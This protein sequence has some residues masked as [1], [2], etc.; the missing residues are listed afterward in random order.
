MNRS[1]IISKWY[2]KLK[3]SSCY[4]EEFYL[5]LNKIDLQ[6]LSTFKSYDYKNNTPQ[7]NLLACL[8]FCEELEKEYQKAG[9]LES[10]L[11]DSLQDLVLW[12]E[13]YYELNNEIGLTEL[14]WISR[15][16]LMQIFRLGRLQFS[17]FPSEFD[18]AELGIKVNDPVLEV[19]IP[20]G[21]PLLYDEC[22]KSFE[23]AKSFFKK[24]YPKY[25]TE[26]CLCHSWLLDETLLQIIG[27]NSN[28]AKFQTLFK[29]VNK[30]EADSVLRYLFLWNTTRENLE[31]VVPKSGFAK[32]LQESVLHENRKLY[33]ALGIRKL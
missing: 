7:K 16:F 3:F 30:N 20:S 21:E 1:E 33:E 29:I 12:N 28:V 11:L 8:Y 6:D 19:H 4:D 13:K 15:T 2:R 31:S 22:L 9:I 14:P 23:Q 10:I 17:M 24:Y 5:C 25:P 32:R 18:V 27:S 26:W